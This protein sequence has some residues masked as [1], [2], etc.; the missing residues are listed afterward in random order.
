MNTKQFFNGGNLTT[1]ILALLVAISGCGS[2]E[3]KPPVGGTLIAD[4]GNDWNTLAGETVN[5]NGNGSFSQPVGPFTFD[6]KFLSKPTGSSAVLVDADQATPSFQADAQGKY[7]VELTTS[8]DMTSDRDTVTIATFSVVTL[9]GTYTNMTP[10]PDVGIRKLA[11]AKD[12]LYATCEF[13]TIGGITAYKIACYD[14]S[15]WWALGSGLEDGSI[16]DMIEYLDDLYVTGQFEMIGGVEAKNIAIWDGF[17]WKPVGTGIGEGTEEVGYA[18]EVFQDELYIGGRFTRAGD[19]L[20]VN[21]TKWDGN[22]FYEIGSFEE[23]SVRELQ[24]YNNALY[25][26]GFFE[27]FTGSDAESIARYDGSQWND[28]GSTDNLELGSTGVVRHMEVFQGLLFISG[29]FDANGIDISELI[30][31]DG[32]QYSDFG[33][34]FSLFGGNEIKTLSTFQNGL[35]IGGSFNPVVGTQASNLLK[36]DGQ[37]WAI[38]AEGIDGV[39]LSIQ[40]FQNQLYI[41]GEFEQAGGQSA[42]NISIWN[43]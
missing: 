30:T 12:L 25:A 15:K 2:D 10:G 32:S 17:N 11:V 26:G 36:W 33:R 43:E 37:E 4:A 5:L 28:L 29:D 41:G 22:K 8:N 34:A 39:T 35:Y 24:V 9:P 23:G 40:P 6:W 42:E 31:Y 38:M 14:G 16:F 1:I 7:K 21:M 18:L 13:T 3:E 27:S 19:D 20:V